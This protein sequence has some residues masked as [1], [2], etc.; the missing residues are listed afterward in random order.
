MNT[1][2]LASIRYRASV[3]FINITTDCFL[4][5]CT[6]KSGFLSFREWIK[7][8]LLT[9]KWKWIASSTEGRASVACLPE[10][11]QLGATTASDARGWSC[12]SSGWRSSLTQDKHQVCFSESDFSSVCLGLSNRC[13]GMINIRTGT[14]WKWSHFFSGRNCTARGSL[15][16]P[17]TAGTQWHCIIWW[18]EGI[19]SLS[20]RAGLCCTCGHPGPTRVPLLVLCMFFCFAPLGQ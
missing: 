4:K 11:A 16:L 13:R 7:T 18:I 12:S 6:A 17:R 3:A 8:P 15:A 19:H 14:F 20:P 5:S 1:L 9:A 2:P 10:I